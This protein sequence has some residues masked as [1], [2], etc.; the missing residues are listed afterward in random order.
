MFPVFTLLAMLAVELYP[1]ALVFGLAI[2]G[3]SCRKISDIYTSRC[4]KLLK[5]LM[6]LVWNFHLML[7]QNTAN[8]KELP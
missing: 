6:R 8:P 4:T 1:E 2:T 7:P 5:W 3:N